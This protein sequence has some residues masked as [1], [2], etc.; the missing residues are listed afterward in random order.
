[1]C[2]KQLAFFIRLVIQ[3]IYIP[4]LF[5]IPK[6]NKHNFIDGIA[7]AVKATCAV[8]KCK[9]LLFTLYCKL[10]K[11]VHNDVSDSAYS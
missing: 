2:T 8:V 11:A 10:S 9:Q 7:V 1:M 4:Q 6:L 3:Y 5:E